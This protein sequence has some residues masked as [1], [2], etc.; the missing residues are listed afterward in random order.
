MT[1]GNDLIIAVENVD[2]VRME[3]QDALQEKY[4]KLSAFTDG[5]PWDLK[6]YIDAARKDFQAHAHSGISLGRR[7]IV[8]KEMLAHGEFLNALK[9]IHKNFSE[10]TARNYMG[11]AAVF[12]GL[13]PETISLLGLTKLY[14]MLRAP[15]DEIEKFISSGTFLG[16][17]KDAIVQ[18][19]S[20]ELDQLV[21]DA[22]EKIKLALE[23]TRI[24]TDQLSEEVGHLKKEK[25]QLEKQ[26]ADTKA[27]APPEE[28]LPEYWNEYTALLAALTAFSAKLAQCP[29]DFDDEKVVSRCEVMRQRIEHEWAHCRKFIVNLPIDP[30]EHLNATQENIHR[31]K[32]SGKFDFSKLEE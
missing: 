14:S 22:T 3:I 29:N 17:E 25:R 2:E 26:L 32:K 12:S 28:K 15:S 4:F 31:I 7:L 30:V 19:S 5:L 9:E 27:G 21:K 24:K 18:M 13:D 10:R 1:S 8:M 20:R 23:E 6:R 11:V 16:N